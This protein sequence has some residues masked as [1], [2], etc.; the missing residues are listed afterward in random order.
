MLFPLHTSGWELEP[1]AD[2]SAAFVFFH[3]PVRLVVLDRLTWFVLELCDG[4]SEEEIAERV[5]ALRAGARGAGAGTE[6]RAIVADRLA[7]LRARGLLASA[8]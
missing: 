3:S 5:M 6:G 8:A 4:R 2:M 1:F 7:T